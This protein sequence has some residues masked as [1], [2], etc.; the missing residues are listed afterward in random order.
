[1]GDVDRLDAGVDVEFAEDVVD[2]G[3]DGGAADEERLG[4]LGIGPPLGK[5][6]EDFSF[7]RRQ[8]EPRGGFTGGKTATNRQPLAECRDLAG[9]ADHPEIRRR[10]SRLLQELRGVGMTVG[11]ASLPQHPGVVGSGT[12]VHR[13]CCLEVPRS[14]RRRATVPK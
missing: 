4:N 12:R 11:G 8:P 5:K 6:S 7:A 2:V 9:Q 3:A 1:M 13:Q 10:R 14:S